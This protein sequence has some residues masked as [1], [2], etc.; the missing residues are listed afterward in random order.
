MNITLENNLE[1]FFDFSPY[2]IVIS[3]GQ[4]FQEFKISVPK[5][6]QL[7]ELELIWKLHG[8]K[9]PK[10]YTPIKNNKVHVSNIHEVEVNIKYEPSIPFGGF[11]L[12]FQFELG[13]APDI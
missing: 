6:S 1:E 3:I 13:Y 2:P 4:E 5:D 8:E 11:S 10:I 7:G 9:I 12:P